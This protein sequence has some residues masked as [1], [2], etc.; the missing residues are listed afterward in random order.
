MTFSDTVFTMEIKTPTSPMMT[1]D[2]EDA[3]LPHN[4]N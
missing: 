1:T 4:Q 3:S 2:N